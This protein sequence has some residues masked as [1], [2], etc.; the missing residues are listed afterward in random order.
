[1]QTRSKTRAL[2]KVTVLTT[3]DD[4]SKKV[5]RRK[6]N[7]TVETPKVV[8]DTTRTD[9]E[10][11]TS[12]EKENEINENKAVNDNNDNLKHDNHE[13]PVTENLLKH[14]EIDGHDEDDLEI[15]LKKA[16]ESLRTENRILRFPELN[17]GFRVD[18]QL[19]IKT[20]LDGISS[21]QYEEV[22]VS[23]FSKENSVEKK[24]SE[25]LEKTPSKLSKKEKRKLRE[26]T[27][28]PG[29]FDMPKPE[30]T[31]EVKRDLQVIKLRD[32]LDPKRFYKKDSSKTIPKY[33]QVGTIIEGP[34]EFYSSR[35]PRKER[36]QTIVDELMAD[37]QA[38]KYYKR[39]F[40][41]IQEVKQSG[42]KKHNNKLRKKRRRD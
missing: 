34:T 33:F 35:L 13:G 2:D 10:G 17:A 9:G 42:R 39:K 18:D 16:E 4:L 6:K 30:L 38:K 21:L 37:D 41:E 23:D 12:I 26:A 19:Y 32:V 31:P 29:W 28:G 20:N 5:T 7:T 36:K 15:L 11:R 1:M 24:T 8:V 3:T 22:A 25:K 27:A 40:L 14:T